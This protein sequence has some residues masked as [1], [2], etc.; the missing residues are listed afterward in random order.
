M[1]LIE[2]DGRTYTVKRW[3]N[4]GGKEIVGR[5]RIRVWE[6]EGIA[7]FMNATIV[8][9][10]LLVNLSHCIKNLNHNCQ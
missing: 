3:G 8:P 10:S 4:L 2:E 5:R 1:H 7:T 6:G 9:Y